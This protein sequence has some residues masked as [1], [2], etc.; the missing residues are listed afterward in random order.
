MSDKWAQVYA[1]LANHST[2]TAPSISHPTSAHPYDSVKN[3][4]ANKYKHL[5]HN[6]FHPSGDVTLSAEEVDE[7][8]REQMREDFVAQM[9]SSQTREEEEQE[10]RSAQATL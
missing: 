4:L 10:V 5:V 1:H 7:Q 8:L 3:T 2:Y 6:L 9:G